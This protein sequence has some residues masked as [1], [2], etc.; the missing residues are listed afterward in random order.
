MPGWTQKQERAYEHVKES[1]RDEGRSE[2]KASEIAARVVNKQRRL[3]GQT[4]NSR[5]QGTGNP[6]RA[7]DD[8]TKDE[9]M[10]IARDRNVEGRSRMTKS[11]LV[12][13][14]RKE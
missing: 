14:L 12:K 9:L 1:Y 10:N 13:A 6:R 4:A 3:K 5:T 7:L 2:K 8:R 11:E